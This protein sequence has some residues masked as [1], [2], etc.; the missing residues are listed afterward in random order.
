MRNQRI[1][2]VLLILIGT[3]CLLFSQ[4]ASEKKKELDQVQKEIKQAQKNAQES[5][6]KK[7]KALANKKNIANQL[8]T[9]KKKAQ[10]LKNT[11]NALKKDLNKNKS[12]IAEADRELKQTFSS[13]NRALNELLYH[14]CRSELL[15]ELSEY[16]YPISF[17]INN[18]NEKYR[19]LSSKKNSLI[20]QAIKTEKKVKS[21]S[22]QSSAESKK[23]QT[24]T[25]QSNK[26]DKDI[27]KYE[28]DKKQ[29]QQRAQKLQKDA[30]ELQVLIERLTPK[31]EDKPEY[32]Y[33]FPNSTILWPAQGEILRQYGT[34]THEKYKV[35]T[36]N[37]GLD[38]ALN[39]GSGVKASEAGEVV[40]AESFSGSGE[41]VIIDHKNGFHTV[42]GN[43]CQLYVK[44]G[45]MVT[46]G[47]VIAQ[48]GNSTTLGEP[49]LHFELR[50]NGKP[51]NPGA[52][53]K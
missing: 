28:K 38:I 48:S 46:R 13:T 31:P 41:M 53:L 21:V 42:Y 14:D 37:N 9:T 16:N 50:R 18:S 15:N 1:I 5:E 3:F 29:Y 40:Y 47:Q 36:M 39:Y 52:Y 35:S 8:S 12:Q 45:D 32:S 11:E 19:A 34:Q 30:Q 7:K 25:Q 33:L 20:D 51:I 6:A 23:I 17:I 43:N 44:K 4:T 49:C 24:Y 2:L 26:L 27:S 10:Q 22:S